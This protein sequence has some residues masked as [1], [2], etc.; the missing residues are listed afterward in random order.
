MENRD[1]LRTQIAVIELA[2]QTTRLPLEEFMRAM[3]RAE[4]VAPMLDPTL[5]RAA[6]NN[7]EALREVARAALKL[8]AAHSLL[9]ASVVSTAMRE[10]QLEL[11]M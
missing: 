1:Y 8:K 3:N 4:T 9:L 7:F 2:A 5:Y 6:Q 10:E 11:V